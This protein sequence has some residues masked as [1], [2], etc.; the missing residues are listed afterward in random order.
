M[1]K[2]ERKDESI[3]VL[4]GSE[5]TMSDEQEEDVEPYKEINEERGAKRREYQGFKWQ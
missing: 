4:N 2:E 5:S 3:K 1:R